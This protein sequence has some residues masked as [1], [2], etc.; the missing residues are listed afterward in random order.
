MNR[1]KGRESSIGLVTRATI[2]RKRFYSQIAHVIP[3]SCIFTGLCLSLR[4]MF[5][6]GIDM[7]DVTNTTTV[8]L[9]LRLI[10]L[11]NA[12]HCHH[13]LTSGNGCI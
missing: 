1:G 13:S 3:D 12:H 9:R 2:F 11:V 4:N 8:S 7:C 6:R 5:D 10:D